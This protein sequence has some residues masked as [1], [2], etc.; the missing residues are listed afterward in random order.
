[1]EL[2][3]ASHISEFPPRVSC[4]CLRWWC[5]S[6]QHSR[7][8][9]AVQWKSHY[10]GSKPP[11]PSLWLWQIYSTSLSLSFLSCKMTIVITPSGAVVRIKWD[12]MYR[13]LRTVTGT[14]KIANLAGIVLDIWL[15]SASLRLV[16]NPV[17]KLTVML[18]LAGP[19]CPAGARSHW[20]CEDEMKKVRKA[21]APDI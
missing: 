6:T 14:C 10:L 11:L 8:E 9:R 4:S 19:W 21:A 3:H 18:W 17:Q 1:M 2:L 7:V 5:V 15:G 13:T 16:S 12:N 20:C